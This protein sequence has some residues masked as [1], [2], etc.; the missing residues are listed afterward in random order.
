MSRSLLRVVTTHN[1][2]ST[3][4]HNAQ[5]TR[6][7]TWYRVSKKLEFY[8]IVSLHTGVPP[9]TGNGNPQ[10]S[11]LPISGFQEGLQYANSQ[12]VKLSCFETPCSFLSFLQWA[13]F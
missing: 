13:V 4:E 8:R 6:L 5:C 10:E 3:E 9:A 2:C 11:G 1:N 7:A 12:F